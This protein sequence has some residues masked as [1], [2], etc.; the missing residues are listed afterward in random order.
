MLTDKKFLDII[1][2]ILKN[3]GRQTYCNMYNN[4]PYYRFAEFS[5]YLNPI[6]QS[7]NWTKDELSTK[8]SDYHE[9]VIYDSNADVQYYHLRLNGN[10]V[11]L[12]SGKQKD[13]SVFLLQ[14]LPKIE[15]ELEL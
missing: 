12:D 14:Y 13:K 10:M 2:F 11:L 3:G 5:I 6:N 15:K 4:S 8:I 1:E 9:V 7:I